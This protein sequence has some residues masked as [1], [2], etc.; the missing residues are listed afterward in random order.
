[1]RLQTYQK[2]RGFIFVMVVAGLWSDSLGR[3][4]GKEGV[5]EGE[6]ERRREGRR[7]EGMKEGRKDKRVQALCRSQT[8]QRVASACAN[9]TKVCKEV[10]LKKGGMARS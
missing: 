5:K 8:A 7:R 4:E 6:Q 1:M 9:L 10:V 2:G 3:K